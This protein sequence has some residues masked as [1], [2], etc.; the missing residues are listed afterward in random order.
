M[1]DLL[2]AIKKNL[3]DGNYYSALF[4]TVMLPS[5]CGALESVDGEDKSTRYIAWY[6]YRQKD[7]AGPLTQSQAT[8]ARL[9]SG[10]ALLSPPP[11]KG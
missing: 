7:M 9:V 1:Q 4:L 5:I 10:I 3:Q 2:K 8:A 11:P 6:Y